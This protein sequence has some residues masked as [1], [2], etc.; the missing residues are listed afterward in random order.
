MSAMQIVDATLRASGW[1]GADE[2][3]ARRWIDADEGFERSHF[4]T[5]F[6]FPDGR[7]RF[8]PD[9]ATI[10]PNHAGMPALP[11][12]WAA[13]DEATPDHPVPPGRRP[14]PQLSQYEL[15]RNPGQPE[16]RGPTDR[17]GSIRTTRRGWA[18]RKVA[19]S[20]W[21]TSGGPSLCMRA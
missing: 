14:G 17:P 11:D 20:R 1:P 5:G 10:G 19:G 3:I 2:V 21:A 15:Y 4:L 9:W 12:H 7:F 16:A 8:A 18:L 6:G 13:T